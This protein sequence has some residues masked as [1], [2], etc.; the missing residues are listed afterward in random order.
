MHFELSSADRHGGGTQLI[1]GHGDARRPSSFSGQ[2]DVIFMGFQASVGVI[3]IDHTFWVKLPFASGYVTEDPAKFAFADP[4]G[5]LDPE[6]GLSSALSAAANPTLADP[7]RHSGEQLEE[8]HAM[9]PGDLVARLLTSADPARPRH[10][11]PAVFG[12]TPDGRQLR[13]VVLTGLLLDPR[14]PSTYTLILDRYGEDVSI[15]RPG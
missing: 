4:A 10:D 2:L 9:L 3:S 6:R 1:G 12:I 5:L 8:V 13:R 7:D 14:Q 11:V 15:T